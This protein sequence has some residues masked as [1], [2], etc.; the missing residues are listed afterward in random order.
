MQHN[1]KIAKGLPNDLDKV[2]ADLVALVT[3]PTLSE[4]QFA[5]SFFT[6]LGTQQT[7]YANAFGFRD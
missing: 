1:N 4:I 7:R 6:Y 2:T 3:C 5:Y